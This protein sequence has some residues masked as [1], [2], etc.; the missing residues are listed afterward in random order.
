MESKRLGRYGAW[1]VSVCAALLWGCTTYVTTQVTA[2]SD[3]S[4][5]DATR[6]YAFT[7]SAEQRNNLEQDTYEQIVANE[8]D[9]Y[10][11]TRVPAHHAHYLVGLSY[12]LQENLMTV[13]QPLYYGSPWPSPYWGGPFG[14]PFN[15]WGGPFGPFP[16]TYVSQSY[17]VFTHALNVRITNRA[18]GKEVYNVSAR[19]TDGESSLLHAMPYLARGAFADFPLGNGVV[20]T[21]QIP[22][23]QHPSVS[24]EMP[25][26]PANVP[27]NLPASAPAVPLPASVAKP[28][29]AAY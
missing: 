1:M 17:P 8:L 16:P 3:W 4:G 15:P 13:T 14:G 10:A 18:T 2:F 6:T 19:S 23:D 22:L 9:Q 21:V 27:A 24:N 28:A 29:A 26:A 7:R 11:F 12:S 25:V 20:R 5:S